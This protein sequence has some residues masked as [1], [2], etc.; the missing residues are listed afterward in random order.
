LGEEMKINCDRAM[1]GDFASHLRA[2]KDAA[3]RWGTR[4]LAIGFL[5]EKP[6][7]GTGDLSRA[8]IPRYGMTP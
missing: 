4:L 6:L 7:G 1:E 3:R 8:G 5:A 2:A